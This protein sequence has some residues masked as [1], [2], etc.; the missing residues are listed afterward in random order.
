VK[1][2][3]A[4]KTISEDDIPPTVAISV[5]KPPTSSVEQPAP[6]VAPPSVPTRHAPQ[7]PTASVVASNIPGAVSAQPHSPAPAP[8]PRAVIQPVQM[9]QPSSGAPSV[10][11]AKAALSAPAVW[12][13]Q[14]L[15]KAKVVFS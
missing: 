13:C 12:L 5:S 14:W 6:S 1:Q 9:G 4:G 15:N 11:I 8:K 2:A 7:P 3:K 10:S